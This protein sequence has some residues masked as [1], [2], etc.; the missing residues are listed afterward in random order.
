MASHDLLTI[1]SAKAVEYLIAVSYLLLFIPFWRY[2][3]ARPAAALQVAVKQPARLTRLAEWFRMAEG[4]LFHPG[5]AWAHV[6]GPDLVTVGLDDFTG[7]LVGSL[8]AIELPAVGTALGQGEMGWTLQTEMGAIDMLSPVDGTVF[9]VNHAVVAS[10]RLAT[11]APY[12]DGWLLKI[13]SR[14]VAANVTHLLSG[15]LA[16]RWMEDI[17]ERLRGEMG[18]ELGLV[19]EDGGLMVDGFARV[20]DPEH[21]ELVAKRLLLTEGGGPHV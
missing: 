19:Y 21:P 1:Y 6:D 13:R 4:V 16:R 17:T 2:V 12:E 11:E 20:L 9:A 10:P 14:R 3:N 7:K 18:L 8:L 15:S 5:H